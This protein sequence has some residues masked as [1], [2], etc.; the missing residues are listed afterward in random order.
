[1][2][3]SRGDSLFY[4]SRR[5]ARV[6]KRMTILGATLLEGAALLGAWLGPGAREIET[7]DPTG[8][9]VLGAG[10]LKGLPIGEE[11]VKSKIQPHLLHFT[12]ISPSMNYIT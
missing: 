8:G 6:V 9:T 11:P 12:Q 2:N 3:R 10:A 5:A 1:M 7:G 4:K